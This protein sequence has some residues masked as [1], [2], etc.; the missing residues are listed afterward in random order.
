M[1]GLLTLKNPVQVMFV[2]WLPPAFLA[3]LENLYSGRQIDP[4][5]SSLLFGVRMFLEVVIG[6]M[7]I[8]SAVQL[9]RKHILK[10]IGLAFIALILS[11]TTVNVLL[12]Y[13]E[14]FSTIM[15]TLIQFIL[16]AEVVYYQN[17]LKSL[18]S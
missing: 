13:F 11:L 1:I 8:A 5:S 16:L 9:I 18:Q 7:F 3:F 10:G 4:S 15:T 17:K 6:S 12:F 14:Q 2:D